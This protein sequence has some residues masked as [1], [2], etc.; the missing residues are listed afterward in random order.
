LILIGQSAIICQLILNILRAYTYTIGMS[1]EK[2]RKEL[3]EV[4]SDNL[5][6]EH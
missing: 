3:L 5:R 1:T 2:S 6:C 4:R